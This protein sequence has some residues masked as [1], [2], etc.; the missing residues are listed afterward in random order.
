M[1]DTFIK[2]C[3]LFESRKR[4]TSV[5]TGPAIVTNAEP[6]TDVGCVL[7]GLSRDEI[8]LPVTDNKAEDFGDDHGNFI[9]ET[10]EGHDRRAL[11][12]FNIDQPERY[13]G[14]RPQNSCRL[15]AAKS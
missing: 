9:A 2:S 14:A 8:E 15:P 11:E 12:V 1:F 13:V 3:P 5:E 7:L 4:M 6:S 10:I